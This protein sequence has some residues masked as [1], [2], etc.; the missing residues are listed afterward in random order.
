MNILVFPAPHVPHPVDTP[1]IVYDVVV[2]LESV[3]HT[4]G[5]LVP[6]T[7]V[8]D[9]ADSSVNISGIASTSLTPYIMPT[10]PRLASTLC[11]VSG[12]THGRG[13]VV[14]FSEFLVTCCISVGYYSIVLIA[15]V[16]RT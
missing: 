11:I 2:I 16:Y 6:D 14:H 7:E 15:E 8:Y 5:A 4:Y 10:M 12:G 13:L 1:T 3:L 9:D